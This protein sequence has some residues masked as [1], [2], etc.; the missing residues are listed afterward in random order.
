MPQPQLQTIRLLPKQNTQN[1]GTKPQ[2]ATH[3][4]PTVTKRSPSLYN[5]LTGQHLTILR[6]RK[7]ITVGIYTKSHPH[8]NVIK[9]KSNK[10]NEN[11]IFTW[12][13]LDVFS[14]GER[15]FH[16]HQVYKDLINTQICIQLTTQIGKRSHQNSWT[17]P[18]RTA[19]IESKIQQQNSPND[20]TLA[21]RNLFQPRKKGCRALL[22]VFFFSLVHWSLSLF[23]SN[24]S[25]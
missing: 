20:H 13:G 23:F 2:K 4:T 8:R 11:A 22:F 9:L 18:L 14:M 21:A 1:P 24:L 17:N 10:K 12:F 3:P 16:Y 19:E 5:D 6:A 7:Q 25:F 15:N